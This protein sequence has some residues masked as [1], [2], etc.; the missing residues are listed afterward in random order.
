MATIPSETVDPRHMATALGLIMGVGEGVGGVLSPTL[1]GYAADL[2]GLQVPLWIMTVLPLVA[3]L[4]ALG[5]H[6]TAPRCTGVAHKQSTT[7]EG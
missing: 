3:A 5:L 2:Y 6:E 7:A 4:L 1:A